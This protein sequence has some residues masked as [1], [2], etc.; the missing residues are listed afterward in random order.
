MSDAVA[1]PRAAGPIYLDNQS[2]TRCDPRVIDVML[3]FFGA[4]YGNPHS[5]EH[6]MGRR[7]HEAV[8]AAR[9]NV[10]ALVGAA[11]NEIV[12]TSGATESNNL[13]IKGA[14][15]YA[16][17]TNPDRR[18]IITL[19][20]EH[21]CVLES[22]QELSTEGFDCIVLPVQ[23]DGLID[24]DRLRAALQTPTLLVSIM[25]VN[26]EIGVIHDIAKLAALVKSAGALLHTDAAQAAGKIPL[27][28]AGWGVDLLS[29]SSHKMYGP[30]GAGALFVR[31]RPRVRLQPLLSGGGQE[32]G[33]R[34]GYLCRPPSWSGSGKRAASRSARCM[35]RLWSSPNCGTG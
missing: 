27:D 21:K 19:V 20:T 9:A 6:V 8:E 11:P 22:V 16:R 2:T 34:S 32:R 26:N 35:R 15:H 28:V 13:A 24:P 18:R 25:V 33:L 5:A 7:A 3:P 23:P 30:K 31:R 14:A 29:L 17:A 4:E 12:F 1:S 10:A